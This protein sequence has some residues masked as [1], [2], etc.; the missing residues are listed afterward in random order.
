MYDC[1][2]FFFSDFN[3]NDDLEE[4]G[5][6]TFNSSVHDN[7]TDLVSSVE[8]NYAGTFCMELIDRVQNQLS[9]K[10]AT[11]KDLD[12]TVYSPTTLIETATNV[13][14]SESQT[15]PYGLRGCIVFVNL[16]RRKSI[17]HNLGHIVCDPD[18]VATFE[19]TLTFKEGTGQFRNIKDVFIHIAR[20]FT[21]KLIYLSPEFTVT[22]HKLY[23]SN[24]DSPT[25]VSRC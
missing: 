11:T 16:E 14:V 2:F 19:L 13:I 24:Q 15:E 8:V 22:K 3:H 4:K 18:T 5:Y 23:R 20:C 17:V 7:I 12:L 10:L 1:G 25:R 9:E 6:G 21:D